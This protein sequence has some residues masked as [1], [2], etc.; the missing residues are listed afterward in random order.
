M[1]STI[2]LPGL[3]G[4]RA[5]AAF[6]VLIAHIF[7][8]LVI[9]GSIKKNLVD[10]FGGYSVDV[11]FTLSGFL[12]TFLLLK[13]L[14]KTKEINITKFYTRRLLRIWPLYYFYLIIIILVMGSALKSNIWYYILM[15]PNIPFSEQLVTGNL[16]AIPLLIH[17]WSLGVEEQFYAFWPWLVKFSKNIKKN[18]IIFCILYFSLKILLSLL[19]APLILQSFIQ[20]TRFCCLGIGAVGACLY[21]EKNTILNFIN[22]RWVVLA[23]CLF[24]ILYYFNII[25]LFSII[26]H[27]IIAVFSVVIIINQVSVSKRLFSLENNLLDYLGKISFGIY[28][29]NPIIIYFFTKYFYFLNGYNILIQIILFTVLSIIGT[30]LVSHLSYFYFEN[31][32]LKLKEKFVVVNSSNSKN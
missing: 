13:E 1:K 2:Y 30:I 4:I 23:S 11:F 19:H 25:S 29:Y 20:N 3:N 10:H 5:I 9:N 14:E 32:F 15:F 6:G 8:E 7:D 26:N 17:Y 24:L 28:I 16:V 18:I 31:K 27:E 22:S 21:F 12:I